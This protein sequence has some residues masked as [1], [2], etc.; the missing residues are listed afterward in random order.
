[1]EHIDEKEEELAVGNTSG[2]SPIDPSSQLN[3]NAVS[4]TSFAPNEEE[5]KNAEE[6]HQPHKSQRAANQPYRAPPHRHHHGGNV[7]MKRKPRAAPK[8]PK[9][10]KAIVCV[11]N[12]PPSEVL[13][14][15][16]V[17]IPP[18]AKPHHVLVKVLCASINFVDYKII[19]GMMGSVSP[20]KVPFIA[21]KRI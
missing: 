5:T 2:D 15:K 11:R 7:R 3:D 17:P 12:G 4:Y 13:Q 16:D 19:S 18:I 6:S 10:M 20:K 1:M 14:L 21:G 9:T 8:L